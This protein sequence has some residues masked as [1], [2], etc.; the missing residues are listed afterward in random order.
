MR[1]ENFQLL[2]DI[3]NWFYELQRQNPSV[4]TVVRIGE[5]Y[6][7]RNITGIVISRGSGR[8]GIF[9]EAGMQGADWISPATL[10]YFANELVVGTDEESRAAYNDFDWYIFPVTNPDGYEFTENSVSDFHN[11]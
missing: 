6:E 11:V 8:K 4:V 2:D 9:L 7:G 3:N 10:T 5:T 1:W